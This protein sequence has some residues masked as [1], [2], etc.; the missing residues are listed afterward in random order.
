MP[1]MR[2]GNKYSVVNAVEDHNLFDRSREVTGPAWPEF[3]FHDDVAVNNWF[4]LYD[5]FPEY[6]FGLKDNESGKLMAI[7]NSIPIKWDGN[8]EDLPDGG[9][10]WAL[11]KGIADRE[12][13]RK[14]NLLCALQIVVSKEHLG[15]GLSRE[16][17]LEMIE[18]G[19]ANGLTALAAPVRPNHKSRF[20][21]IPMERYVEW[22]RDDELPYDPWMRVH[23]RLGAKTIK[24]CR[25][26]MR[27]A[28]TISEWREWT[29]M[30]F[31]GSGAYVIQGAL[32]P[33]EMDCR[34]DKGVYLEPNV[35]MIHRIG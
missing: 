12:A 18:I 14:P 24:V 3:M 9:F 26:S 25:E 34:G 30:E 27:I 17:I 15:S 1:E 21:L 6:Q 29:G 20:P 13:E 4:D 16:A 23:T 11:L 22:C 33:V 28:G 31:P 7:G 19:R 32:V 35:W 8:L 2:S 5:Q 10:D